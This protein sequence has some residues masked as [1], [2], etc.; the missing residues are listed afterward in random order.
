VSIDRSM[1]LV[2]MLERQSTV[3]RTRQFSVAEENMLQRDM[4]KE[5]EKNHASVCVLHII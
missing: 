5:K 3:V 2:E 4:W 1:I